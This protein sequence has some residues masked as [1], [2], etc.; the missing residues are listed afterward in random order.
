MVVVLWWLGTM[1]P[2]V[3]DMFTES[4]EVAEREKVG[5][6]EEDAREGRQR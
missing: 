1:R 3:E 4:E 6:G 2:H 5:D